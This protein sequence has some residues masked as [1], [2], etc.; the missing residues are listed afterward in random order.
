MAKHII[1]DAVITVN[2][3]TLTDHAR[4]VSWSGGTNS[5]PAAAMGELQDYDMPSTI[6]VK[7]ILVEFYQDYAGSNV[8]IT[9]KAL[10]AAASSF[11]LTAKVSSAADS[12]TN[13]NFTCSVF[14]ADW[15]LLTGARGDVHVNSVTYK[16]AAAMTFDLS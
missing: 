5:Q 6:L 2:G 1:Y 14:I 8:Y 12:A 9:H 16:A 3:V 15:D 13:P 7:P 11:V 10:W 4:K